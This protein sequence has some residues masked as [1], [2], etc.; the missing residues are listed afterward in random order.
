[1]S[2]IYSVMS[3]E[4]I[5]MTMAVSTVGVQA[6]G[7]ATTDMSMSMMMGNGFHVGPG[8]AI[9]STKFT[10]TTQSAY[11]GGVIFLLLLAV[12]WRLLLAA[13][14]LIERRFVDQ[15]RNRRAIVVRG[16]PTESEKVMKDGTGKDGVLISESGRQEDVR[17][18]K[19]AVRGALPWRFS[20]DLPRA[21][22]TAI[23]AAVG[24]LL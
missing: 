6:T 7:A 15:E 19:R 11:A 18:V 21:I 22:M 16:T 4:G 12:C 2:T 9:F 20:Q 10:P 1:M 13:R 23:V 3:T 14:V 8:D 24:Y 5:V 17:I